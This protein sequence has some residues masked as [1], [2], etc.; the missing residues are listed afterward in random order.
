MIIE[1]LEVDN[2]EPS[3]LI[4]MLEQVTPIEVCPLNSQGYADFR[5]QDGD[6]VKQVERKTWSDLLGDLGSV[7]NQLMRQLNAHEDHTLA[8][9]VEGIAI[10]GK[11]LLGG[12]AILTRAKGGKGLWIQS[13]Q[14][15]VSMQAIYAWM[16][17]IGKYIEVY[18]TPDLF[19][20]AKAIV[21][22]YKGDQKKDHNTFQRHLKEMTFHPNPQVTSLMGM[23]PGIGPVKAEALVGR[24]GTVWQILNSTPEQLSV[25]YG[26]GTKEAT[27]WLR[28]IGRPDV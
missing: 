25:V 28:M 11:D 6:H 14:T 4:E 26:V 20:T 12:T 24:F 2:H 15:K 10:P 9:L 17:Q 1:K 5:W 13:R 7:E 23:V 8:L 3:M 16:Y 27:R 21:A 19:S 22:F 18:Q